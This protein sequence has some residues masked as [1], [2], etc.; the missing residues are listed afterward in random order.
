[1]LGS[2]ADGTVGGPGGGIEGRRRGLW[3]EEKARE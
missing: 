2:G 3:K 1:M